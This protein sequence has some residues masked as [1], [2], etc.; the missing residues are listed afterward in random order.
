MSL[1]TNVLNFSWTRYNMEYRIRG[2]V[3]IFL[4]KYAQNHSPG[5]HNRIKDKSGE[6]CLMMKQIQMSAQ[7]L[8]FDVIL[9]VMEVKTNLCESRIAFLQN[10]EDCLI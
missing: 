7:R 8:K 3:T 6:D 10:G 1:A 9:I 2:Y 5:Q 4:L